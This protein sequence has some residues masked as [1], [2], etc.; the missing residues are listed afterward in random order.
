MGNGSSTD[1]DNIFTK[2]ESC[3]KFSNEFKKTCVPMPQSLLN[4]HVITTDDSEKILA[5]DGIDRRIR[6]PVNVFNNNTN[7]IYNIGLLTMQFGKKNKGYMGSA[8]IIKRI[9]NTVYLLTAAH[10]VVKIN[11]DR[12]T[13][14]I[15]K[16]VEFSIVRN[17]NNSHQEIASYP[18]LSYVYHPKYDENPTTTSGYDIAIIKIVIDL[19]KDTILKNIKPLKV[20]KFES[21]DAYKHCKV[22]G[23]PGEKDK[24][25][26]LYGMSGDYNLENKGKLITYKQID[27]SPGQSGSPI[28]YDS[29]TEEKIVD[30]DIFTKFNEIVGV[31]TGGDVEAG[32][33]WGTALDDEKLKWIS[34]MMKY[35]PLA[36]PDYK[37]NAL[38]ICNNPKYEKHLE[39]MHKAM[40]NSQVINAKRLYF[41]NNNDSISTCHILEEIKGV[42]SDTTKHTILCFCGESDEKGNWIINQTNKNDIQSVSFYDIMLIRFEKT[43]DSNMLFI[44]CDCSYAENWIIEANKFSDAEIP[45]FIQAS[46]RKNEAADIGMFMSKYS[47]SCLQWMK[48]GVDG[49]G[50][51]IVRLPTEGVS[52][53]A[54]VPVLLLWDNGV[55]RIYNTTKQS[56]PIASNHSRYYHKQLNGKYQLTTTNDNKYNLMIQLYNSWAAMDSNETFVT[57]MKYGGFGAFGHC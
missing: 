15:A 33:N 30:D 38:L 2:F 8:A 14:T 36:Q 45:I 12:K 16:N 53:I 47:R 37:V 21:N 50:H 5:F 43:G 24:Q 19:G 46:A 35:S 20:R 31:H 6:A 13:L 4:E 3:V 44:I 23:F 34:D 52:V 10:N 28:F 9:L 26:Q 41:D 18:A 56:Q 55:K 17:T 11:K 25:G 49:F 32:E 54:S 22:I 29:E 51:T 7:E 42:F 1:D 57:S 39:D 40:N 48:T 27:T